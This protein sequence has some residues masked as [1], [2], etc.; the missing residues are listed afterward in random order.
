MNYI[1]LPSCSVCIT[2]T[3]QSLKLENRLPEHKLQ[4]NTWFCWKIQYHNEEHGT[5]HKLI[6]R[7]STFNFKS[8]QHFGIWKADIFYKTKWFFFPINWQ[9]K[10]TLIAKMTSY[11]SIGFFSFKR[12]KK[13]N[14]FNCKADCYYRIWCIFFYYKNKERII[15]VQEQVLP[16]KVQ[17]RRICNCKSKWFFFFIWDQTEDSLSHFHWSRRLFCADCF[18]ALCVSD[19]AFQEIAVIVPGSISLGGD[20]KCST[21]SVF[22]CTIYAAQQRRRISRIRRK[23][24]RCPACWSF[25]VVHV[26]SCVKLGHW[27]SIILWFALSC[28]G[29]I[30]SWMSVFGLNIVYFQ[31]KWIYLLY[32]IFVMTY[33][34]AYFL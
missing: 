32:V 7:Q 31:R 20:E 26:A 1:L 10:A 33:I 28:Y 9:S 25:S 3:E 22:V 19:A 13:C 8:R 11:K 2:N 21:Y 18:R 29:Y 24:V 6:W 5:H 27:A 12:G 23:Y 16:L 17:C 34:M 15:R 4:R 30:L 14:T